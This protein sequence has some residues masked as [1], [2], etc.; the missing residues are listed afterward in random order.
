M[1]L[2]LKLLTL[3]QAANALARTFVCSVLFVL[4]SCIPNLRQGDAPPDIPPTFVGVSS[5]ENSGK[6]GVEEFFKDPILTNLI[7]L[8]VINNRE[9]KALDEEVE[10]ARN[11]YIGRSGAYLPFLNLGAGASLDRTGFFTPAGAVERNVEYMP[12]KVFP[13]P[14]PN[15]NLGL[16]FIWQL[17]IFRELRN[18]RDAFQQRYF[19]A[20]E[21]RNFFVTRMVAD[22]AENY[23]RLQA[24]DKRMEIVNQ[25]IVVQEESMRLAKAKF[26]AG[27]GTELAILRFQA[28]VKKNQSEKLIVTQDIVEAEN[29]INFLLNRFPQ[30]VE[31]NSEA[32]LNIDIPFSVGVPPELLANRPD[33]RQAEHELQAAGLDV[34][35]A[36]AQFFP[37]LYIRGGVG[38]QAINTKYLFLTPES[39]V[40]NVAGDLAAPLINRI[41]IKAQYRAANAKQLEALYN[42]QRIV[43]NGYIEVVNR[44]TMAENYRRSNEIKKEQLVALEAS[45]EASNKLFQNARAEYGEVLFAQRDLREARLVVI[46]TKRQQLS[47]IVGVYQALGGGANLAAPTAEPPR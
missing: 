13:D 16:N 7:D 47:A 27:K 37:K 39:V 26:E 6:L 42:Y 1:T 31:R 20:I 22:I 25:Q 9:L 4:P 3:R 17:D 28:D 40:A 43:L 33:I 23:Y 36:R 21:R 14:I 41:A 2:S 34:L 12:G 44:M 11:E 46:E 35:V 18:T 10:V 5:P 45:V 8:A 30:P 38:Y 15:F 29:R 32:F 24:L 19:A